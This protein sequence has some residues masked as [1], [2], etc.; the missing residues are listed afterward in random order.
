MKQTG[1]S[2]FITNIWG[3]V[4]T[5]SNFDQYGIDLTA[6]D[7]V[8]YL[9]LKMD[10]IATFKLANLLHD[11][12]PYLTNLKLNIGANSMAVFVENLSSLLERAS[13]RIHTVELVSK[14]AH[15]LEPKQLVGLQN[16]FS[17]V[18]QIRLNGCFKWSKVD[19]FVRRLQ[20][21]SPN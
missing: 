10:N 11:L 14:D 16:V 20:M 17:R 7:K 4:L 8:H 19:G 1:K 5:T 9:E 12:P 6:F 15:T 13:G 2:N 21:Y 3:L 18:R